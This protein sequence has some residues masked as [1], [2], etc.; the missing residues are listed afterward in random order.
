MGGFELKG[1]KEM[2]M[3]VWGRDGGSGMG[4]GVVSGGY[5]CVCGRGEGEGAVGV[6]KEW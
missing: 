4:K 1:M 5:G 6:R 2:E 3:C